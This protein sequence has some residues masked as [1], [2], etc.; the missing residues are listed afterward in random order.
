MAKKSKP[1]KAE[2]EKPS[3][4]STE[5]TPGIEVTE[6]PGQVSLERSP[7]KLKGKI[8]YLSTGIDNLHNFVLDKKVVP[9]RDAAKHFGVD[10]KTAE[11][12]GRIL[13]DHHMIEM[14]YPVAGEPTLR[15]VGYGK[16]K[17][18]KKPS[19]E[20]KPE[21]KVAV[22]EVKKKGRRLTKKRLMIMAELI[23]L[24]EVLI[25]I[26]LVNPHL[27]DNFVPTL[28]YQ[29]ANLP[30]NLTNLLNSTGL[31]ITPT[32]LAGII[33]LVVVLIVIVVVMRKKKGGKH[34]HG[35]VKNPKKKEKKPE[36][37]PKEKKESKH[38]M[39]LG[40]NIG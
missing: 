34:K 17:K 22:K 8:R 18:E 5:D 9:L 16:R 24:F 13:E 39:S 25:Y 29:L 26:F 37:P 12:W 11:D 14:H 38:P 27:R 1:Q 6:I 31:P 21:K 33:L 2:K 10:R 35:K 7:F 20:K 23:V 32:M 40:G 30:A 15:V 19:K 36:R 28:N 3:T 4:P